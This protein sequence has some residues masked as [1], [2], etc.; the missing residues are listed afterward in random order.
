VHP[1]PS[2]AGINC[3]SLRRLR[4][5]ADHPDRPLDARLSDPASRRLPHTAS[6]LVAAFSRPL[7]LSLRRTT[8]T[9]S[10]ASLSHR[11]TETRGADTPSGDVFQNDRVW[12][13]LGLKS[14][15]KSHLLTFGRNLAR[16]REAA[17]LTQ[18][19]VAERV[20][21]SGRHYQKLEAGSVTP[22]FGVLINLRRAL[23]CTWSDLFKSIE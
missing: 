14:F 1:V 4:E 19:K 7:G 17:G 23:C 10:D 3:R 12:D 16:L 5:S 22:T 2:T 13:A 18:E 21:L 20:D 9:R 8:Q 15:A 6:A 11:L